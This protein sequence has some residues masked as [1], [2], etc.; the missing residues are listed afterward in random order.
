[1]RDLVSFQTHALEM[2]EGYRWLSSPGGSF[3]RQSLSATGLAEGRTWNQT[4]K[5][6]GRGHTHMLRE[7]GQAWSA[8]RRQGDG[9]RLERRGGLLVLEG[10][11]AVRICIFFR[12]PDFCHT[13]LSEG[14]G[15]VPSGRRGSS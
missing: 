9:E 4:V 14:H 5:P 11:N 2:M 15:A 7:I 10:S 3:F 8:S 1:M 6:G 12:G 13:I